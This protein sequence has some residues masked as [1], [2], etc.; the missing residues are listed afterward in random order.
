MD[1]TSTPAAAPSAAGRPASAPT[2]RALQC[3]NVITSDTLLTN[4]LTCSENALIIGDDNVHLDLN[5][6]ALTGPGLGPWVWPHRALSSVGIHLKGRK[7]AWIGNGKVTNFATGVLLD[8][9]A[10][11][12]INTVTSEGN[13]YGIYLVE[14]TGNHL[15]GNLVPQNTYGIH[16][17]MSSN[18]LVIGNDSFNNLYRSPGGY[19]MNLIES[20]N[21]EIRENL[22]HHNV[23]QGIWLISSTGNAIFRNDL[24]SNQPNAVDGS[25]VNIWYSVER[26]EDNYW[27]D[28]EGVDSDEDGIGNTPYRISQFPLIEDLYPSMRP[29]RREDGS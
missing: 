17:Q 29:Y 3:G 1:A 13:F 4:D 10:Q 22:V 8:N 15:V 26:R 9:S 24:I 28:Y 5:G 14:S 19:G 7:G 25:D 20:H 16:L 12:E 27:S 21:N 6:H 2:P 11:T 23:N 18:N